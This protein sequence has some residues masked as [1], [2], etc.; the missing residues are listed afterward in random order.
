MK[1]NLNRKKLVKRYAENKCSPEELEVFFMLL[2]RGELDEYLEEDMRNFSQVD[3]A[4]KERNGHSR[5][6]SWLRYVA[7]AV[8]LFAVAA[9]AWFKL[10]PANVSNEAVVANVSAEIHAP[11]L[12]RAMIKL[13]NGQ[14]VFLDSSGNG[15]LANQGNVKI[16]RNT[17][18]QIVYNGSTQDVLYNQL[19]NPRGSKVINLK[20]SDGSMVWLNAGSSIQ[21]PVSFNAGNRVVTVTGEAYFE[22]AKNAQ[23]PFIANA[24]GLQVEVLGTHFNIN[25]YEDEPSI[26]AT[27]LEGSVK[28][29]KAN[30]PGQAI[31]LQP[32]QQAKA[33]KGDMVRLVENTDMEQVMAWKNGLFQFREDG[34]ETIMRQ[35]AC[36]YDVQVVFEGEIP[37]DKFGGNLPRDADLS[38]ILKALEQSQVHFRIEGKKIIVEP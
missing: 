8:I 27:L 36:W 17:E 29:Y 25:A 35:L 31:T 34:I 37:K 16:E 20:L 2:D 15:L 26:R 4:T 6:P 14:T 21:Y 11:G 19:Y 33:V 12:H 30:D 9:I 13:S 28:V 7:A 22:V 1:E 38:V 23:K 5:L 18:G 3:P 10:N 24:N 32:G